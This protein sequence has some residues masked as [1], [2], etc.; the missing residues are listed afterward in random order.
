[1]G[2]IKDYHG[3]NGEL[4]RGPPCLDCRAG[5]ACAEAGAGALRAFF[6]LGISSPGEHGRGA[7]LQRRAPLGSTHYFHELL[8]LWAI[9]CAM[10]AVEK[11][12]TGLD[13]CRMLA[14]GAQVLIGFQFQAVFQPRFADLPFSSKLAQ[15]GGLLLL[16]TSLGILIVPSTQH[17]IAE[18]LRATRRMER[19][20]TRCLDMSL[21]P[22]AAALALDVGMVIR[23]TAGDRWAIASGGFVFVTAT[24]LWFAWA[25]L[26]SRNGM[27]ERMAAAQ[28]KSEETPLAKQIDQMLTE[29]RTVLPGAQA[30]LGFQLTVFLAESFAK[31]SVPLK[32]AHVAALLLVALTVLL[33]MTPAVYHRVV[34]AGEDSHDVLRVGARTLTLATIPLSVALALDTYV[35]CAHGLGAPVAA[36]WI[37]ASVFGAL[38]AAWLV[39]P[40]LARFLRRAAP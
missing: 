20:L 18:R 25:L 34:Y 27:E 12:K 39:Y 16:L 17:I 2:V 35:V 10:S 24:G 36:A 26:A 7:P 3:P 1:M 6:V 32:S 38:F 14:L 30:L 23:I 5:A 11:V 15:V 21:L 29:A 19:I 28:R 13:E 40:I 37:G 4:A 31:L 33:L 22:L 8:F 9:S